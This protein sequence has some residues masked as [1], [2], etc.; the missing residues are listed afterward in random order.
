MAIFIFTQK[1]ATR[2][3]KR[4]NAIEL[5][6]FA[7]ILA[8]SL[9]FGYNHCFAEDQFDRLKQYLVT[10]PLISSFTLIRS[11]A[12][13]PNFSNSSF[14]SRRPDLLKAD[15]MTGGWQN[16]AFL[17]RNVGSL[18]EV[19]NFTARGTGLCGACSNRFWSIYSYP[20][21]E[22]LEEFIPSEKDTGTNN[23]TMNTA[24]FGLLQIKVCLWRLGAGR[25]DFKTAKWSGTTFKGKTDYNEEVIGIFT[26]TNGTVTQLDLNY[27]STPKLHDARIEYQYSNPSDRTGFLPQSY[28]VK[29]KDDSGQFSARTQIIIIQIKRETLDDPCKEFS[30][31]KFFDKKTKITR[32]IAN[33]SGTNY[34]NGSQIGSKKTEIS[35]NEKHFFFLLFSLSLLL[36]LY[37]YIRHSLRR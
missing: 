13:V 2:I 6:A 23:N 12:F 28:I 32:I 35:Q 5:N 22:F 26:V 16:D 7:C 24:R 17:F 18:D 33:G 4:S 30:P 34:L 15:V 1:H 36:P 10:E 20:E 37:F 3:L 19:T 29:N 25:V 14:S 21:G 27:P 8:F 31:N 11:N 9:L